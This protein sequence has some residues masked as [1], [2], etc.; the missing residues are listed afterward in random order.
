MRIEVLMSSGETDGWNDVT[1]ATVENGALHVLKELTPESNPLSEARI[2]ELKTVTTLEQIDQGP[3]LPPGE[4]KR[5][6]LLMG[7]YAPGMWMKVVYK[8]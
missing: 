2:R 1:D 5:V 3:D 6:F 4:L 8:P 7:T